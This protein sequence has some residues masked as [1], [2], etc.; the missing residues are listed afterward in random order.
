[1]NDGTFGVTGDVVAACRVP[2]AARAGKVVALG[3]APDAATRTIDADGLVVA[4]GFVETERLL[5]RGAESRR[6]KMEAATSLRRIAS[7]D[8]IAAPVV[9]LASARASFMC[10]ANIDV[11]GGYQRSIL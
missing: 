11:D 6:D 7:A 3:H 8:E 9:F 4:P 2:L 5:E 1:M 10:G